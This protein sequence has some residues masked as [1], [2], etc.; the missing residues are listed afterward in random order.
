MASQIDLNPSRYIMLNGLP[1]DKDP[2][3]VRGEIK[4]ND[5]APYYPYFDPSKH[6]D[7]TSKKLEQRYHARIP[8][9]NNDKKP[10]YGPVNNFAIHTPAPAGTSVKVVMQDHV[11][12]KPTIDN[13]LSLNKEMEDLKK[14]LANTSAYYDPTRADKEKR[15]KII[16]DQIEVIKKELFAQQSIQVGPNNTV[17]EIMKKDVIKVENSR[18]LDVE[19]TN[20]SIAENFW[21]DVPRP[22]NLPQR[23]KAAS[24]KTVTNEQNKN[25]NNKAVYINAHHP[26]SQGLKTERVRIV[27]LRKLRH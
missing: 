11:E 12:I 10:Y 20:K 9:Y 7:L 17:T 18:N 21:Y 19:S 14:S 1:A 8:L 5:G 2:N 13:V 25:S 16:T 3:V 26:D 24:R 22:Q 23:I 4:E 27:S 6:P 15:I